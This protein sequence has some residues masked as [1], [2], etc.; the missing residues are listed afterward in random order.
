MPFEIN[1]KVEIVNAW[2]LL[3]LTIENKLIKKEDISKILEF[4]KPIGRIT[5]IYSKTI[6]YI[7]LDWREGKENKLK[8]KFQ[9][10]VHNLYLIPY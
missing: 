4:H 1:D 10:P 3:S 2:N 8:H 9:I 6:Y 5:S 7:E